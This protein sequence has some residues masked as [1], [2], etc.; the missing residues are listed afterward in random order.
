VRLGPRELGSA[1]SDLADV[2]IVDEKGQQWPYLLDRSGEATMPVL[3]VFVSTMAN[4]CSRHSG[5]ATR[6]L[7]GHWT[8]FPAARKSKW[9]RQWRLTLYPAAGSPRP[10]WIG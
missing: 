7:P 10:T 4:S 1:R 2:R 6:R 8:F 5:R 9:S 3:T